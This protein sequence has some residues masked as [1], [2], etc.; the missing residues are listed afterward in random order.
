MVNLDALIVLR[1]MRVTLVEGK[2]T[3]DIQVTAFGCT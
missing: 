1:D 2:G 3:A